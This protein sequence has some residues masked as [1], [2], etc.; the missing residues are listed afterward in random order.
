MGSPSALNTVFLTLFS[1][2]PLDSVKPPCE[3]LPA[4]PVLT[5]AFEPKVYSSGLADI[6][7]HK[8]KRM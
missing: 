1:R 4:L 2:H 7:I 6:A 8:E 5:R 3:G